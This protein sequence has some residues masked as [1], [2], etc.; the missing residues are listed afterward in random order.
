MKQLK[1]VL[2]GF[3]NRGGIYAD[4]SLKFPE[5]LKIVG[6]VEVNPYRLKNAKERYSLADN[7]VFDNIDDFLKTKTECD[8]VINA[9]MDQMHYDIAMKILN[10]G[11]NMLIE[12]PVTAKRAELLEI[13]KVAKEKKLKVF[14]CHV[15]RYTPFYSKIKTLLEENKIGDIV[16][17]QLSERVGMAHF[18]DSFVRGK[19]GKESVCGSPLLLAKSCHD[20]DLLC[21]LNGNTTPKNVSSFGSRQ[22]FIPENAPKGATERCAECPHNTTCLYDANKIHVEVDRHGF[23]T[24]EGLNKP[25][26]TITKEEK[27]E[28]LKTSDYG[29]C[30][31]TLGGD[32]VDRQTLIVE[33]ANGSIATFTLV[34]AV[35]QAG[36]GIHIIG[37]KGEILGECEEG[38]IT[39]REFDRSGN[40]FGFEPQVFD[41]NSEIAPNDDHMGGDYALMRDIVAYFDDGKISHSLTNIEDSVNGHLIVYAAEESRKNGKVVAVR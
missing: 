29:R 35:A 20:A 39:L 19:W 13:E 11:Y 27:I 4:Y 3:G 25:L 18:I 1:A 9:T 8:F 15:L 41:V 40:K 38:I 21:W 32:L 36:R 24:W 16:S 31:Y 5:Q 23:Q 6:V 37:T 17:M 14:V 22:N 34:G 10:A 30:V 12:K 28:Y 33:Y 2:V 26:E 7:Q